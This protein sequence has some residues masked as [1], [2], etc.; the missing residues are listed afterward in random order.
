[1]DSALPSVS[2][3]DKLFDPAELSQQ[4][5]AFTLSVA[6]QSNI[7]VVVSRAFKGIS[8]DAL[9][10]TFAAAAQQAGLEAGYLFNAG[11]R[12]QQGMTFI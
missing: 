12:A 8:E 6:Y 4:G 11:S 2:C 10:E 9:P 1:M 7:A 3:R 5:H